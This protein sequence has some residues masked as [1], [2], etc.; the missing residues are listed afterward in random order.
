MKNARMTVLFVLSLLAALSMLTWSLAARPVFAAAPAEVG[1]QQ[2]EIKLVPAN[3][4]KVDV[5][6]EPISGILY[7]EGGEYGVLLRRCAG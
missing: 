2:W 5:G 4:G 1:C 7:G 6:W 3:T